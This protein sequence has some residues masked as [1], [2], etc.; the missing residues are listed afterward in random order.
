MVAALNIWAHSR[1]NNE[2]ILLRSNTRPGGAFRANSCTATMGLQLLDPQVLFALRF[3]DAARDPARQ[4]G[5]FTVSVGAQNRLTSD[6]C[7]RGRDYHSD[8]LIQEFR[9]EIAPSFQEQAGNFEAA[10]HE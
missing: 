9:S 6:D 2:D 3:A 1:P 7:A 10:R 5:L 8:N 4:D